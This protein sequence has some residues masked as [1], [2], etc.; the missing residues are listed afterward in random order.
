VINMGHPKK[1][2]KKYKRPMRPF[3]TLEEE[4]KLIKEYG[5][6]KKQE[7]WRAETELKKIR[8]RAMTLLAKKD[9]KEENILIEKLRKIG[10]NVN[11]LDDV[12]KL[13]VRDLLERRLQTIVFRKGLSKT[14]KHARQLIAHGK[15]KI[16][17]RRVPFPSFIVPKEYEDK[18]IVDLKNEVDKNA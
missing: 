17:G 12:L 1:L 2:K 9:L 14:I 7:L 6:K 15:V 10:L 16:N 11:N 3:D 13:T 8:R 18:I 5:L 4:R